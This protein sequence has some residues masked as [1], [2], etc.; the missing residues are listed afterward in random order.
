MKA[1]WKGKTSSFMLTHN[2]VYDVISIE[3]GWYRVVDDSDD[4]YLYPPEG[5]EIVDPNMDG[6]LVKD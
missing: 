3:N 4:D 6:V 1:K 2:K 5:F